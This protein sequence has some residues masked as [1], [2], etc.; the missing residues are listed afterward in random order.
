M[1]YNTFHL[2]NRKS[3][4]RPIN[5]YNFT[6]Q[7]IIKLIRKHFSVKG[8]I[9]DCGCGVGTID[10]YLASKGHRVVGI[11]ISK[12]A[13]DL[14]NSSKK[15]MNQELTR[16]ICGDLSVYDFECGFD[17]FV[18]SEVLEHCSSDTVIVKKLH[19]SLKDKGIGII[20]V[21]SK[22][23]PLYRLGLLKRFD[24]EVG[25][26]RRYD[27]F[28]LR[29]LF[30]KNGFSVIELM[31]TEGILRNIIYT[32][33]YFGWIVRIL[34]FPLTV[35]FNVIDNFLVGIFGESNIYLVVR[36]T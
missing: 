10:F 28:I 23:A 32:Q 13:I 29:S 35:F 15:M 33:P 7:T 16:F 20:S 11:D 4:L 6:Y 5:E 9:I 2:K 12:R 30:E 8:N 26:L 21:P 17:Y 36:K 24:K 25:H 27:E 31:K 34:R 3:Q 1:N 22:K 14:A 18:C 19:K